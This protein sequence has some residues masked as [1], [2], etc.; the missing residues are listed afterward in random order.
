MESL[1]LSINTG[2]TSRRYALY[3]R[4]QFVASAHFEYVA[5]AVICTMRTPKRTVQITTNLVTLHET[6]A[7]VLP[8]LKEHELVPGEIDFAAVGIRV[9]G[10]SSFLLQHRFVDKAYIDKL[11]AIE[12]AS[13]LIKAAIHELDVVQRVMA[14]VPVFAVSDSAFHADKPDSAWNYAID[15]PTAD[16]H[17][18]KR[19]GYHGITVE[20]V[21]QILAAND[22]QF[23]KVI[24]CQLGSTS[25]VTAVQLGRSLETTTGYALFEGIPSEQ[26]VGNIPFTAVHAYKQAKQVTDSQALKLLQESSGL[27]GI[28]GTSGDMRHILKAAADGNYRAQLAL[29]MY[30]QA[31][32]MAI[33]QMAAVL[34]GADAIVFTGTIGVRSAMVRARIIDDLA[35]LGFAIQPSLNDTVYEP[36]TPTRISPRTRLKPVLVVCAD[37]TYEIAWRTNQ[38]LKTLVN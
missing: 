7:H 22:M 35:F 33:G 37:E 32:K 29:D 23:D 1:I 6:L 26:G 34:G 13:P 36:L 18:I 16:T 15:L 3:K 11:V 8:L 24:I 19:F 38:A 5:D 30:V 2:I 14:N 17:E 31:A 9:A 4:R 21:I 27:A 25:S 12:G 28:S 10:P 20:S